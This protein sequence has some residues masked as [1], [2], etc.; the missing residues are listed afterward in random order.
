[1]RLLFLSAIVGLFGVTAQAAHAPDLEETLLSATEARV[2]S[3]ALTLEAAST[4]GVSLLVALAI[5][6]EH[7]ETGHDG[8]VGAFPIACIQN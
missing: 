5:P 8:P 7:L 2:A 4:C 6:T 1:M 3:A